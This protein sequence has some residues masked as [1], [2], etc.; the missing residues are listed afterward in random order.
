[1]SKE[2]SKTMIVR[3]M[4]LNGHFKTSRKGLICITL[5]YPI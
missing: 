5:D 4:H 2:M 1:M 3:N